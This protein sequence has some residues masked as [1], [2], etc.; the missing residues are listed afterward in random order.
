MG[1][2]KK[3]REFDE[4][5]LLIDRVEGDFGI[6]KR[7]YVFDRRIFQGYMILV[8][9]VIFGIMLTSKVPIHAFYATCAANGP[10][11]QNPCFHAGDRCGVYQNLEFLTPGSVIG[12]PPDPAFGRQL[13]GLLFV[14][15]F[16][17]LAAF[18]LNKLLWNLGRSVAMIF[19][20][21]EDDESGTDK[22][23]K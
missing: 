14:I 16:G 15:G 13:R 3:F 21:G 5:G 19:P 22:D 23:E 11:C 12:T 1:W 20:E 6:T 18:G 8:F 17:F 2:W 4:K 10:A 9:L 7:G